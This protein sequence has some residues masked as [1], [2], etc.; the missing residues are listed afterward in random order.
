MRRRTPPVAATA[1]SSYLPAAAL[2]LHDLGRKI[3]LVVEDDVDTRPQRRHG[4]VAPRAL[5]AGVRVDLNLYRRPVLLLERE[6]RAGDRGDDAAVDPPVDGSAAGPPHE[7]LGANQVVAEELADDRLRQR[8]SSGG[9]PEEGVHRDEC[10]GEEH[11]AAPIHVHIFDSIPLRSR[12]AS[13]K[14]ARRAWGCALRAPSRSF[15]SPA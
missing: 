9:E 4:E 2:Y 10:R 3:G 1:I 6:G 15:S 13:V 7:H 14:R 5:D 8:E 11:E 12:K